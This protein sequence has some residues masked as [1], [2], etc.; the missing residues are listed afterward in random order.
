MEKTEVKT[1]EIEMKE[2]ALEAVKGVGEAMEAVEDESMTGQERCTKQSVQTAE[3]NAKSHSN[4]RKADLY[5][6]KNVLQNTEM[7][8]DIKIRDKNAE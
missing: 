2:E 4:L 3:K 7:I 1:V 6:A 5:I 8:I